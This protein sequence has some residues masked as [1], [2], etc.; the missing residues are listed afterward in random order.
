MEVY[1]RTNIIIISISAP[2]IREK[3]EIPGDSELQI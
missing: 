1:E 3:I 2:D